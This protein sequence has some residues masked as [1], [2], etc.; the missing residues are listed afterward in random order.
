MAVAKSI[1]LC[2]TTVKPWYTGSVPTISMLPLITGPHTIAFASAAVTADS[3]PH[4][5]SPRMMAR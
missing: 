1:P 5:G 2:G 3:S 4:V